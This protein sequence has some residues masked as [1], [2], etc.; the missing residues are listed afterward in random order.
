[1]LLNIVTPEQQPDGV[2][3]IHTRLLVV[4]LT[5]NNELVKSFMSVK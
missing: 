4:S 3:I 1:M 5:Q 2:I